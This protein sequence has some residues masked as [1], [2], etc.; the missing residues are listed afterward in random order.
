MSRQDNR[1]ARTAVALTGALHNVGQ[2]MVS[3]TC[4][5]GWRQNGGSA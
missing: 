2:P 4:S 1:K 3:A 5:N